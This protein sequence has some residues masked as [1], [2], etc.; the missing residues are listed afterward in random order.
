MYKIINNFSDDMTIKCVNGTVD[1]HNRVAVTWEWPENP[2]YRY[3]FV[4][5]V[6]EEDDSLEQLLA[7][8]TPYI[9]EMAF[10]M[11]YTS[12]IYNLSTQFK[13]FSAKKLEN[14]DYLVVN[15]MKG[16]S[17]DIFYKR[18]HLIYSI[19][20]KN[21]FMS[22]YI[23]ATLSFNNLRELG[24]EYIAYRCVGR[25]REKLLFPIDLSKFREQNNYE[26][27]LLKNER[28]EIAL[29]EK[30]REYVKLV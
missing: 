12:E 27:Y 10:G 5:T 8:K 6:E 15:Q 16:N 18:I 14:G 1:E 11:R 30:Q 17:S 7:S 23:K 22:D 26:L 20:Y 25:G 4:F 9:F 21:S 2:E 28:I 24:D 29:N 13:I 3:C 19:K